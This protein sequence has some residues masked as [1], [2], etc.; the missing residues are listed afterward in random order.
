MEFPSVP[1]EGLFLHM[2]THSLSVAFHFFPV[3][4]FPIQTW[5]LKLHSIY[6]GVTKFH[7][8]VALAQESE[9]DFL[10]L[11]N[12]G[13]WF[14]VAWT[15]KFHRLHSRLHI[16]DWCMCPCMWSLC[17]LVTT[18]SGSRLPIGLGNDNDKFS[19]PVRPTGQVNQSSHMVRPRTLIG[20]DLQV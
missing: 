2:H 3:K 5:I 14:A 4:H 10:W 19:Q 12:C 8:N 17:V 11:V 15:L 6:E 7:F 1:L 16:C 18:T 13:F 9:L 20:Q